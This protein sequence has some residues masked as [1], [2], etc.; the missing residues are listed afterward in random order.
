MEQSGELEPVY[1]IIKK[2]PD[3]EMFFKKF[4]LEHC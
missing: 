2:E 4:K 3:F 1:F